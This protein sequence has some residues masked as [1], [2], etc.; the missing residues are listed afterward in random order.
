MNHCS[1]KF[2]LAQY[3]L[4]GSLREVTKNNQVNVSLD[5]NDDK[6]DESTK[7]LKELNF[8]NN[9]K[10]IYTEQCF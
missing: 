8:I 3:D 7:V 4:K 10:M 1:K 2:V 6:V 5:N 9:E